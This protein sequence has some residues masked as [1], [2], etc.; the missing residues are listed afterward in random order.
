MNFFIYLFNI[1]N[2][3]KKII[4]KLKYKELI[5]I[6]DFNYSYLISFF[7]YPSYLCPLLYLQTP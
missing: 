2:L 1:K 3:K 7:H 4:L 5:L 6:F